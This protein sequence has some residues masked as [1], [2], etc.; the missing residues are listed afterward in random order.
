MQDLGRLYRTGDM[1]RWRAGQLEAEL[2]GK[3]G[4]AETFVFGAFEVIGRVDRQAGLN[5][6]D[7]TRLGLPSCLAVR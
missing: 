4:G 6:A 3:R 7:P 5:T 2:E 1:G